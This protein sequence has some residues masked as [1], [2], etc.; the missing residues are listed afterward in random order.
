[1]AS[2]RVASSRP[3]RWFTRAAAFLMIACARITSIGIFSVPISKFWNERC[4]CAPQYLSEGTS[5]D[6]MLSFSVRVCGMAGIFHADAT[7]GNLPMERS[8]VVRDGFETWDA[9]EPVAEAQGSG[10]T[11]V[12][13]EAARAE[14]TDHDATRPTV[15]SRTPDPRAAAAAVDLAMR[16]READAMRGF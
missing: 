7:D 10:P 11:M 15:V 13:D 12:P 4:V 5:I 3:W 6:P 9:V 2:D 16:E 8:V 14:I 1:M